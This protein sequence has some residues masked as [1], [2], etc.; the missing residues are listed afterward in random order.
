MGSLS[1]YYGPPSTLYFL[2][3]TGLN[4]TLAWLLP[5]MVETC[6]DVDLAEDKLH[7]LVTL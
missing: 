6:H 7:L 5:V 4:L 1:I 2:G 3:D